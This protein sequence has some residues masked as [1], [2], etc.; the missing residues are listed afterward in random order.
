MRR[1][2]AGSAGPPLDLSTVPA[3][4]GGC[5]IWFCPLMTMPP[6]CALRTLMLTSGFGHGNIPDRHSSHLDVRPSPD[7]SQ[8]A[9][10][11]SLVSSVEDDSGAFELLLV[12]QSASKPSQTNGTNG[13]E[14]DD[15]LSADGGQHGGGVEDLVV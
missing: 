9:C 4:R 6:S 14:G 3:A 12:P 11:T 7:S 13:A 15:S 8:G 1:T 10:A 5:D 2:G